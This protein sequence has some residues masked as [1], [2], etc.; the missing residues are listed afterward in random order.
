MK[1]QVLCKGE[2]GRIQR[3]VREG[4]LALP[5]LCDAT[6]VQRI[7]AVSLQRIERVRTALGS[8]ETG[9]GSAAG[10]IEIVQRSRGRWDLP[11]S[12]RRFGIRDEDLPWWPLV[13]AIL[14]QGAEHSFSGVVYSEPA[15]PAQ[16]WHI[17]SPHIAGEHLEAHALNVLVALQDIP[18]KMGPTEFAV[19]S[20]LLTN[21]LANPSLAPEEL[22]YQHEHTGPE[23]ICDGLDVPAPE[24]WS[25][26][27][28]SGSCL[29]FDDRILHRGLANRSDRARYVAYFSY[30]KRG[31][32]ENTHFEAKR[33]VF[34][35]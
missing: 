11:I 15:S 10:Y 16:C 31:Y 23:M 5:D 21:H 6:F 29:L 1:T 18:L 22:V 33:S 14:G 12:P 2:D 17:D 28:N 3:V 26:P 32:S 25:G 7:L 9:I 20:H 27:L 30:R 19:G 34:G 24:L 4:F 8:R 13:T 35:S